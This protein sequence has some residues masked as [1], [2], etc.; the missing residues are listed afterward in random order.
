MAWDSGLIGR[1]SE[2]NLAFAGLQLLRPVLDRVR[3]I[4]DDMAAKVMATAQLARPVRL[5][6]RGTPG[7]ARSSA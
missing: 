7:T 4:P 6:S 3:P 1:E 2:Q 5:V